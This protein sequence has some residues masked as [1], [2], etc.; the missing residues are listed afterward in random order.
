MYQHNITATISDTLHIYRSP[1]DQCIM[2]GIT[3]KQ[4][5]P[6]QQRDINL[7]RLYLQAITLFDL[8]TP[9]G[10]TIRPNALS[11]IRGAAQH[12]PAELA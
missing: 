11:G 2:E 8:S 1:Q 12:S 5:T 6:Q 4:Y 3:L 9:D 10:K 7:V